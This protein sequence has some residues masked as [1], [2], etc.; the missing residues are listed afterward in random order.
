MSPGATLH[1]GPQ[2]QCARLCVVVQGKVRVRPQGEE[3]F[4]IGLHGIFRVGAAAA[5]TVQNRA[6]VDALVQITEIKE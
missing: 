5:C 2:A 1:L 3:E 4:A 6:Y